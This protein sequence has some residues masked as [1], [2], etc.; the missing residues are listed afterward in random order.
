MLQFEKTFETSTSRYL[1]INED[2]TYRGNVVADAQIMVASAVLEKNLTYTDG[3]QIGPVNSIDLTI[4]LWANG[5]DEKFKVYT[6]KYRCNGDSMHHVIKGVVGIRVDKVAGFS[7]R[8]NEIIN[9]TNLSEKPF[10]N[11]NDYHFMSPENANEQQLGN[12]RGISIAAGAGYTGRVTRGTT[13]GG[14]GTPTTESNIKNNKVVGAFS[15]HA[16]KIIGI[17]IQ[18]VSNE[19]RIIGNKVDLAADGVEQGPTSKMVGVRIRSSVSNCSQRRNVLM[20]GVVKEVVETG[21]LRK[22]RALVSIPD[23]HPT[24][25][26]HYGETTGCPFARM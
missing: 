9:I 3:L 1:A 24:G 22:D 7:V 19:I 12:V 10:T 18:G 21:S 16:N 11:C 20:N 17:D 14:R 13:R 15:E 6:P 8:E 23:G 25:D 5:I 2:G 26:W 4:V